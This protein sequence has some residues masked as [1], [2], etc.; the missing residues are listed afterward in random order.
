MITGP[1]MRHLW[2]ITA[3]N[4][5]DQKSICRYKKLLGGGLPGFPS[6]GARTVVGAEE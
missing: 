6:G 1:R 5:S 2:C 4:G 3:G